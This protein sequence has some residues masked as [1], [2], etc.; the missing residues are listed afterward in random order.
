MTAAPWL[1]LSCL[2]FALAFQAPGGTET[3]GAPRP[4]FPAPLPALEATTL[5]DEDSGAVLVDSDPETPKAEQ[6][7]EQEVETN[8]PEY[9][10]A[11]P[12]GLNVETLRPVAEQFCLRTVGS[13]EGQEAGTFR[14]AVA[15]LSLVSQDTPHE[16]VRED[17]R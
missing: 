9:A 7:C 17:A 4:S 13:H 15:T 12:K 6:Q 5:A 8:R 10:V 1:R 16:Q 3:I 14:Y 11:L 2:L